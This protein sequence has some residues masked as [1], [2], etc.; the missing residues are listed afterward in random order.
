MKLDIL[1]IGVHPDDVELGCGGTILKQIALGYKVGIVDLTRGELG[2]NGSAKIRAKESEAARKYAGALIRDNLKMADGF[3]E[4][5]KA[6]KLKIIKA[7][8]QYQPDLVLANAISDRHPDHGRASLLV[9]EACF[10]AG[11][12]KVPTTHKG[13]KQKKWRPRK[14]LHYIQDHH[15]KPDVVID[16]SGFIDQKIELVQC[17]GTQ[18]Y[19]PKKKSTVTPIS[20]K[21]FLDGLRGRAIA[22]GRRVG[23]EYGEG[24]MCKEYIG[25]ADIMTVL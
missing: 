3:F 23:V 17:F 14:V 12:V 15:M 10:L 20:S 2:T 16:I 24:F 1:A 6:N 11:L 25:V 18:F 8:R 21:A 7:I 5:N 19:N 4:N 13:K 9:S 22:H